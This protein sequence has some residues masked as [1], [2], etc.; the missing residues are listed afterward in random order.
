MRLSK[1]KTIEKHAQEQIN[2]DREHQRNVMLKIIIV[3]KIHDKSN[4]ALNGE[5]EKIYWESN[6]IFLSLIEMIAEFDPMMQEYIL[7]IKND[8]IHN[9]YL[10]HWYLFIFTIFRLH[11]DNNKDKSVGSY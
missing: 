4:L 6:E 9:H 10:D 3:I 8:E 1:H 11:N 2:R 5:N 7:Q